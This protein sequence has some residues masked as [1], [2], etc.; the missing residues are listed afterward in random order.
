MAGNRP[1]AG[2]ARER[3]RAAT[4]EGILAAAAAHLAIHGSDTTTMAAVARQAG[5]A[6]GTIYV[7][8]PTKEALLQEV[9]AEALGQLKLALAEAVSGRPARSLESDVRQRTDGLLA[10]ATAQPDLA[11]VLFHPSHLSTPAGRDTLEFLV[12]SQA[13]AL[14][15]ARRKGWVRADLDPDLAGR[16]LVGGL[17]AVLGWWLERRA[18]GLPA[19]GAAEVAATLASLRL[20][21]SAARPRE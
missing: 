14:A 9:L 15:E 11:A 5:V 13:A 7:H 21:G 4:R 6:T 1:P 17:V 19:P 8:F 3:S 18:Q 16:A 2:K 10:F 20:Y 12:D